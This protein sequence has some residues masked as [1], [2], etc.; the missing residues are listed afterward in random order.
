MTTEKKRRSNRRNAQASTGPRS[1]AGKARA[2]GNARRHGLAIP[3]WF[4]GCF[5]AEVEGSRDRM[6]VRFQVPARNW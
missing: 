3:L 6:S 5:S 2:A 4:D 1:Q